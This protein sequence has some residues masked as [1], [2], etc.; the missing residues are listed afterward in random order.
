MRV[1]PD[2]FRVATRQK[3]S[4]MTFVVSTKIP[5]VAVLLYAFWPGF[6]LAL[7]DEELQ[8]RALQLL[9]D[10][11][12]LCHN[13][14]TKEG[15]YD[16]STGTGLFQPGDSNE[17]PI[18]PGNPETSELWKR[19]FTDDESIRMPDKGNKLAP[20][21]LDLLRHWIESKEL[22]SGDRSARLVDRLHAN[23]MILLNAHTPTLLHYAVEPSSI[24]RWDAKRHRLYV[25]G[26]GEVLVWDLLEQRLVERWTGLG[27]RI[28]SMAIDPSSRWLAICSGSPG[29]SGA[30]HLIDLHRPQQAFTVWS[31]RDI[32]S[33]I[34]FAPSGKQLA[35]GNLQGK[36]ILYDTVLASVIYESLAHA[37]QVLSLAWNK[38]GTYW[39]SGSRDRTARVSSFP[40]TELKVAYTGHERTV[41]SVGFCDWGPLTLDETGSLRLWSAEEGNR[42]LARRNDLPQKLANFFAWDHSVYW[43]NEN[44]KIECLEVI[45]KIGLG[46]KGAD[47]Q[48]KKK[49]TYEFTSRDF[50]WAQEKEIARVFEIG[51]EGVCF[52]TVTGSWVHI[53]DE[54]VEP[55]ELNHLYP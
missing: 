29:V 16:L 41:C 54:N 1:R 9:R 18:T 25:A 2:L 53:E 4:S 28:G 44:G 12:L 10:K 3:K 14:D 51:P 13:D 20:S 35:I 11:C 7:A 21:E 23:Q 46:E 36:V 17:R 52:L 32:P 22:W 26:W 49:T 15:G 45:R 37:D 43:L 30:V 42:V 55:W 5:F 40:S 8:L 31:D 24:A 19:V 33:A 34:A 50:P 47:G 48:E 38:D 6:T 39:M 27:K